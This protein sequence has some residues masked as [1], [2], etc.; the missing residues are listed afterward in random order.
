MKKYS[1]FISC[2]LICLISLVL[3]TSV[4]ADAVTMGQ[5]L[6]AVK[7]YESMGGKITSKE[8]FNIIAKKGGQEL[9]EKG[10]TTLAGN[11]IPGLGEINDVIQ[12]GSFVF[13]MWTLYRSLSNQT[14]YTQTTVAS[15]VGRFNLPYLTSL[16][17]DG[18]LVYSTVLSYNTAITISCGY[19]DNY[20]DQNIWGDQPDGVTVKV[21]EYYN[22]GMIMGVQLYNSRGDNIGGFGLGHNYGYKT[23]SNDIFQMLVSGIDSGS[24]TS[25]NAPADLYTNPISLPTVT[26]DISN[27]FP[28]GLQYAFPTVLKDGSSSTDEW[29]DNYYTTVVAT[30]TP[31]GVSNIIDGDPIDNYGNNI[32]PVSGSI[33][34]KSSGGSSDGSGF[35]DFFDTIF[36]GIWG[37]LKGILDFFGGLV[38]LLTDM[39]LSLLVPRDGYFNDFFGG[40]KD[41]FNSKLSLNTNIDIFSPTYVNSAGDGGLTSVSYPIF[42]TYNFT[43]PFD[44][45]NPYLPK[46]REIMKGLIYPL[47]VFFNL[48]NIY[49]LIRGGSILNAAAD[50]MNSKG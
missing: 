26:N 48:N 24:Y 27:N 3:F 42:G 47:I 35:G 28:N 32:D 16:N 44:M 15:G 39:L 1:I 29:N 12:I 23:Y 31:D 21:F 14:T 22:N 49:K 19:L 13:D 41:L 9:A 25:S 37:L 45:L 8:M 7:T 2:F 38:K 10:A 5:G 17:T 46:I 11:A 36:K 40:T 6:T 34:P 50:S 4:K 20:S 18:V 43:V 33:T 30:S